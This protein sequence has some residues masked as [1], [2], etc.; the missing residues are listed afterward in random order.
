MFFS[1]SSSRA[2][3]KSGIQ[4][5]WRV[6]CGNLV[7]E[8]VHADEPLVDETEDEL[9]AASPAVRVA[10]GVLLRAVHQALVAERVEDGVAGRGVRHAVA[11]ERREAIDVHALVIDRR[12][13]VEREL[14]AELEVLLAASRRDVNDARA[15]GVRDFVPRDDAVAQVLRDRQLVEWARDR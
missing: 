1:Q 13:N 14:L 4:R 2:S 5:I 10:V 11:R 7:A 6:T 12:D 9:G 15:L 8:L 3:P